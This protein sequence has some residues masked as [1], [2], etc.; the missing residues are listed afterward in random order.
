MGTTI[1]NII[2]GTVPSKTRD[3]LCVFASFDKAGRVASYVELYLKSLR[4]AG[5]DIIFVQSSDYAPAKGSY[6]SIR[7]YCRQIINRKNIGYDFYSWKV[8]LEQSHDLKSYERL[9]ITNDSV[10]GPFTPLAPIINRMDTES[11]TLWGM[12]DCSET[13]SYHLQSY[14]LYCH[15]EVFTKPFFTRFWNSVRVLNQKWQIVLE[16]EVGF[17]TFALAAGV[18]LKACFPYEEVRTRCL[19]KRDDFQFA[20]R[21]REEDLNS[22]LFAA[23]VLL[24]E[25]G[26]P[27]MKT[28]LLRVNRLDLRW[29]HRWPSVVAHASQDAIRVASELEDAQRWIIPKRYSSSLAS[30]H[31]LELVRRISPWDRALLHRRY[32]QVRC[33]LRDIQNGDMSEISRKL[34]KLERF[35]DIGRRLLRRGTRHAPDLSREVYFAEAQRELQNFLDTTSAIS[36]PDLPVPQVTIILI[37]FNKAELT[38]RCLRSL[39]ALRDEPSFRVLIIDNASSDATSNLLERT[40]GATL[41]RNDENVGFLRACNQAAGLVTTPYILFLNNDT[42]LHPGSIQAALEGL[43]D[44]RVGAVGG[45]IV[46]PNGSLQEAGSIF[47]NDGTCAGFGR[48]FPKEADECMHRRAVDYCSG[49]FLMTPTALFREIGGF[50]LAYAPA[51]YEETDYCAQIQ[52]RGLRIIYDPRILVTHVEFGSSERSAAAFDL[53]NANRGTFLKKN[54]L[55]LDTK[56]PPQTPQYKAAT[57]RSGKPRW[58]FL[59]DRVALPHIGAGYPRMNRIVTSLARQ[60]ECEITLACTE[61]F[62]GDWSAI[63]RDIPVDIEVLDLTSRT[64]REQFLRER[65]RDFDVVW[66]SRPSNMER[67][68]K[69]LSPE[70]LAS[71][72]YVL[73]Y[74]SEAI[75]ADR[76]LTEARVFGLPYDHAQADLESELHRGSVADIIVSVCEA[77]AKRWRAVTDARVIIIG[78][79]APIAPGPKDFSARKDILFAGSLHDV[80]SPNVDSLFWFMGQV[81]PFIR[82]Q[83]PDVTV[84]AVGYVDEAL[85]TQLGSCSRNFELVGSVPDL[86]PYFLTHRIMVAPTRFAAGIPQKVFDAAVVGTPTVCSPLIASQMEWSDGV[87]TLVGSIEDPEHFAQRC[88]SLYSD[89]ALWNRTHEESIASMRRYVGKHTI[90]RGLSEVLSKVNSLRQEVKNGS[91]LTRT[92]QGTPPPKMAACR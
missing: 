16:Y 31:V 6:E 84:R 76:A 82:K 61:N 10:V 45:R 3:A 77:D 63:R 55:L 11:S 88:I 47:W 81:M 34:R 46:L 19:A 54:K 69:A 14:F 27:F 89:E 28:E 78:L 8:G 59:D 17:S 33:F 57:I 65:L 40:Q 22:T 53:M 24:G 74:D 13:G 66:V 43:Q 71:R 87:E 51:Y 91:K 5:F 68:S 75:F 32:H 85:R 7:P 70:E 29:L 9:L 73:I 41:I 23:D 2:Q 15:R 86:R 72:D 44:D 80:L 4:D 20:Q 36:L 60:G 62:I 58:L 1:R 12:T 42:I 83:L 49:V 21:I 38:Y 64:R 67:L 35:K 18:Q 56:Y 50:D 79:D 26:F 37:L 30:N 90:E 48:G 25:M 92:N 52:S 39:E